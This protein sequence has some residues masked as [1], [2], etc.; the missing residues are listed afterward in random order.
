MM[1][2]DASG[3]KPEQ[4]DIEEL[5][6]ILKPIWFWFIEL[7]GFRK[8]NGFGPSPIDLH[9]IKLYIE[10]LGDKIERWEVK[11]ILAIDRCYMAEIAKQ[12]KANSDGR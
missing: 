12:Q 4:L 10:M 6:D 3:R 2:W 11:A 7:C 8:S 9:D 5:P 1:A